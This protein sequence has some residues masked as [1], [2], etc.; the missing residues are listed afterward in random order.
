MTGRKTAVIT[1]VAGQDG[2]Y[3]AELLR[4]R[5]YRVV[6]AVREP[7]RAAATLAALGIG[8]VELQ[9][10]DLRDSNAQARMQALLAE[11]RPQEVYNLAAF[12][13]G[14]GMFD[15]PLGMA[16]V[17]G[18][19]VARWLEAIRTVDPA[20]RFCQASSSE[21]FGDALS[22][23]QHEATAL[24]PR[25]PYGAA[26]Q[27]AH[28]MVQ[29]Y[30][31]RF[32][33]FACSAMLF[34]HESPRRGLGFVT[35]KITHHAARI[36][37]GLDRELCLGNL[38]A[39]RDWGFAGDTVRAM[40]SMLQQPASDNYVLATGV[41]HSVRELCAAAFGHLGLDYRDHVRTEAQDF[42][43]PEAAQLVGDPAHA[44]A[45]LGWAATV[46]FAQLVAMMVDA[47]LQQLRD[48]HG[49]HSRHKPRV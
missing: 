28:S 49:L 48:Q 39:R 25:T 15:D 30:R 26:K 37:L 5:G 35:R 17:N 11:V 24:R 13:S 14:A 18:L 19:A 46:D 20:V 36:H 40:W 34:N 43:A 41:T 1:G 45:T 44:R 27:Y 8:G 22:S 4:S 2:S 10:L 33:L 47:D 23:P 12:A 29:I 7:A 32:G 38:D 6:G 42:R 9:A 21:L 31:Q 3:L 16:E